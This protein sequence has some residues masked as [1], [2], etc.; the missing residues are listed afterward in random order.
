MCICATLMFSTC[1]KYLSEGAF[2]FIG[3]DVVS[4]LENSNRCLIA[5]DGCRL[6]I[7]K[8]GKLKAKYYED[9]NGYHLLISNDDRR[10]F[11]LKE[12]ET[13]IFC[14]KF[15]TRLIPLMKDINIGTFIHI[16]SEFNGCF[17]GSFPLQVY[18][19]EY[20]EGSDLDIFTNST[21]SVGIVKFLE[22]VLNITIR[23]RTMNSTSQTECEQKYGVLNTVY[24][25]KLPTGFTIQIIVTKHTD[26]DMDTLLKQFDFDFCK[27]GYSFQNG[28]KIINKTA[29]KTKSCVVDL[30]KNKSNSFL[31]KLD[32]RKAKYEARGFKI[33][34]INS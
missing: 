21:G 28:L 23:P 13:P 6:M 19:D 31:T 33:T 15:V 30:S 17:A 26:M 24:D 25:V 3:V 12:L 18:L 10:Q 4:M 9:S 20:Y 14:K 11:L 34:Y 2:I 8:R 16:A 5:K 7:E 27:I 22:K 32:V 1:S 29:I